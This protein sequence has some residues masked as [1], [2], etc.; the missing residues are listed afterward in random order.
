MP[1]RFPHACMTAPHKLD[2]FLLS[3]EWRDC[4][5]GIEITLWARA[6]KGAVRARFP[7]QEAVMFVPRGVQ[8]HAAR[9]RERPLSTLHGAPIDA[10]YFPSQRAMIAERERL[11]ELACPT[12][13]SDVKPADC[14]LMERFVTASMTLEGPGAVRDG[15][16][17]LDR[18]Q[19]RTADFRPP[20][21]LLALDL[22]TDGWDG[23]LLSAAVATSGHG[24]VFVR[25]AGRDDGNVTFVA[26]EPALL[27][28]LFAE[29][30][31][32]TRT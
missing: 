21:S 20:L 1:A 3:R 23:P 11:R 25:G 8:T 27:R 18:P 28:A 30:C 6:E 31:R 7:G 17:H 32:S 22:E 24:R 2:A 5:D 13:E 10:A 16:L 26:D 9:Q 29:D 19:V 15:V 4:D 14:F 12:F